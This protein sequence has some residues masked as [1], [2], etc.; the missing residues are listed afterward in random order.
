MPYAPLLGF[1]LAPDRFVANLALPE[2]HPSRPHAALI[3]A[4]FLWALRI[5]DVDEL[6]D[7]EGTYIERTI[8]ALQDA[9]GASGARIDV[10]LYK[11]QE[12]IL[13]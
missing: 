1:S 9:T 2:R 5:S 6:L 13:Y 8:S 11:D 10:R 4:V 3:N 12:V 7:H